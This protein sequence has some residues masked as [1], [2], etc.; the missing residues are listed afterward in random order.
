M[1]GDLGTAEKL[2]LTCVSKAPRYAKCHRSLGVLYAQLDKP[3][4]SIKHYK[5]YLTL[6][7]NAQ[8]A[9]RVRALIEQA[10]AP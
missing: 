8:D 2:L 5:K 7:P 9:A 6:A 4:R 3:D 1:T 10:A